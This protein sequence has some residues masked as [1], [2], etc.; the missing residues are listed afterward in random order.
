MTAALQPKHT[1]GPYRAAGRYLS[2]PCI[3]LTGRLGTRNSTII[4]HSPV[5]FDMSGAQVVQ[6]T[7]DAR[8]KLTS[9]EGNMAGTLGL[10]NPFRYRGYVYD[11]ETGLY[12]LRSRYYNPVWGRFIMADTLLGHRGALLTHNAFAY[13]TNNPI[14][15][16]DR[17]G[18]DPYIDL[19]P[20]P[21]PLHEYS[22]MGKGIYI[23]CDNN[24]AL[25]IPDFYLVAPTQIYGPPNQYVH[26]SDNTL[27]HLGPDGKWDADIHTGNGNPSRHDYPHAHDV[28]P[29]IG[30]D[31]NDPPKPGSER[32]LNDQKKRALDN[33]TKS[34]GR[35]GI[36]VDTK[37]IGW[38]LV[39]FIA[40]ALAPFTGGASMQ[41]IPVR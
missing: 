23:D 27:R 7:Y 36:T 25:I 40:I 20:T 8:G 13:C 34:S 21:P 16:S 15:N 9:T 18:S 4:A 30:K 10:D 29:W 22:D 17:N 6:Y 39:A 14:I 2:L 3:G 41:Y 5:S 28:P 38:M 33:K 26:I 12:Y 35:N 37:T 31:K 24:N 32:P 19:Y 11:E 1:V